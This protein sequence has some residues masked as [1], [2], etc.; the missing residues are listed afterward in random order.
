MCI[1][2]DEGLN[3]EI[4]TTVGHESFIAEIY[5]LVCLRLGHAYLA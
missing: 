5:A 3:A 4:E 2:A 1:E